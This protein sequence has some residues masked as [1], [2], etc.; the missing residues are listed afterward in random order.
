[1]K[2]PI[3]NSI[4]SWALDDRPREKLALKGKETLSNAELLSI[5]LGTGSRNESALDLSKKILDAS[6]N[7]L[8]EL[9]KMGLS[10]LKKFKGIG[11]AKAITIEAAMELARRRQ[12]AEAMVRT[13]LKRSKEAYQ[14]LRSRMEDLQV[15]ECWVVFLN[16]A[17]LI[18]SAEKI[19]LGGLTGTV[20]DVRIIFKRALELQATALILSHNH[21]SGNL[22][23]SQQDIDLTEKAK[24]AG[25]ALDIK[26]FDHLIISDQGYYSFA[27]EG[28]L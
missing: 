28:M 20:V 4:K 17:N 10:K 18:L 27:D 5:I 22:K 14:I 13:C 2:T 25:Q 9:G 15:E 7:N 1:M 26:V 3:G 24:S 12:Q 6:G 8:F 16:R 21:P 11:S 23:P 19:S